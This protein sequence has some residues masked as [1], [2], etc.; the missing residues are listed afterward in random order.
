MSE[1]LHP[2]GGSGTTPPAP[3][4]GPGC[5]E[6]EWMVGPLLDGELPP[7]EIEIAERHLQTCSSCNRLAED[8]R[9]L[10]RLARR[11]QEP[12]A[13]TAAEWSRVW[14]RVRGEQAPVRLPAR[15]RV[16]DWIVP[17]LSLAALVLLT[18]WVTIAVMTRSPRL[19]PQAA[20]VMKGSPEASQ[21]APE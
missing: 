12:P 6:Y 13:V 10:E 8:F 3:R 18:A 7:A 2:P 21:P 19:D 4:P 14:E 20:K 15:R 9:S 5:G 17:V 16:I 11:R 1:T